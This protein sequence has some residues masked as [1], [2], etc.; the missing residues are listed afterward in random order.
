MTK[1]RAIAVIQ[2]NP[3]IRDALELVLERPLALAAGA[4][5]FFEKPFVNPVLLARL[6]RVLV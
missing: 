6:A 2:D 3:G 4:D 5:G 1:K